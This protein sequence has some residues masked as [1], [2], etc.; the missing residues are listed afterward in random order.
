MSVV[1][2]RIRFVSQEMF[3]LTISWN[4]YV[5]LYPELLLK[6]SCLLWL[7][8]PEGS[9]LQCSCLVSLFTLYCTYA[10]HFLQDCYS[11]IN[12]C[13]CLPSERSGN[14]RSF[15]LHTSCYAVAGYQNLINKVQVCT[16]YVGHMFNSCAVS[17]EVCLHW[18]FCL[19]IFSLW[20]D[21]QEACNSYHNYKI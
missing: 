2:Y 15:S 21:M 20:V 7:W 9:V 1:L 14:V 6:V 3:L 19:D 5:W 10:I 13:H 11:F 18:F 4:V 17:V 12:S 16:W 8:S